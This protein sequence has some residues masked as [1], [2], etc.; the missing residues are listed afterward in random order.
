MQY[1]KLQHVTI[2]SVSAG[3]I[4]PHSTKSMPC[5]F[6]QY[7][8][9]PKPRWL[10]GRQS[11]RDSVQSLQPAK[12]PRANIPMPRDDLCITSFCNISGEFSWTSA[13]NRPARVTT[14]LIFIDLDVSGHY[15]DYYG[16]CVALS[17]LA[18]RIDNPQP[19]AVHRWR[20]GK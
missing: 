10:Q 6:I 3:A 2:T 4:V 14:R 5:G 11:L 19:V 20:M 7:P 1:F 17:S 13:H 15:Q 12:T 16:P 9:L 8:V 18:T